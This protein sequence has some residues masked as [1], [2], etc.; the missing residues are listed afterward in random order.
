MTQSLSERKAEARKAA[1]TRRAEAH[2]VHRQAASSVL[3]SYM[4]DLSGKVVAGYLPIRTEA[5][6]L[7][8]M[9]ALAVRNRICVPVIDAPG[10]PLSFRE[11]TPGCALE[12]G[13]FRVMVPISG[14]TI[15]PQVVI[16]PLVAFDGRLFR[17]GYGGG[18]YDRTLSL[19]RTAGPVQAIGFAYSGQRDDALP[20]ERT[21]ERL[22]VLVTER[23]AFSAE[24]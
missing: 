20:R 3:Q 17:L 21:D 1:L 5:D 16:V 4:A 14:E 11:W 6:P 19:F 8:A 2:A 13:P 7:P 9:N 23:G 15:R 22:D 24:D 18:F 10:R 12:E